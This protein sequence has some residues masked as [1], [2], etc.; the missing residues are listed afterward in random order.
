MLKRILFLSAAALLPLGASLAYAQKMGRDVSPLPIHLEE[1]KKLQLTSFKGK[2]VLFAIFATSCDHCISSLELL[3]RMQ[4]Q[5]GPQGFQAAA[6]IG[7]ENAPYALVPFKQ[8]YKPNYPMGF[9]NK[10]EIQKIGDIPAETRPFVPIYMFID[11]RGTVRFEF[12]GDAPFFKDEERTTKL[13]IQALL[14]M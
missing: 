13:M 2:V 8:R 7:D 14:K 10:E 5:Y 12:F 9:L 1:G 3:N 4:K 6:A 11:R